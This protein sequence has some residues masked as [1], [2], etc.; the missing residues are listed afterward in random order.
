MLAGQTRGRVTSG[1][2]ARRLGRALPPLAR[3]VGVPRFLS[4]AQLMPT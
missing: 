4:P 3:W 2:Q 1:A